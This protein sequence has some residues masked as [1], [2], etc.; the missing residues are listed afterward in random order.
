MRATSG[1]ETVRS[2]AIT[3]VVAAGAVVVAGCSGSESTA[4]TTVAPVTSSSTSA[5]TTTVPPVT[6]PPATL[7]PVTV[8]DS[9]AC[10]AEVLLRV[11]NE[12][13]GATAGFDRARE[14]NCVGDWAM[15]TLN[16]PTTGET[17]GQNLFHLVGGR[18]TLV[19]DVVPVCPSELVRLGTPDDVANQLASASACEGLSES[20]SSSADSS[21]GTPVVFSIN[22]TLE[23][24]VQPSEW[25]V[26]ATGGSY[27][28]NIT[29]DS[30]GGAEAIGHGVALAST[31]AE[32]ETPVTIRA[33]NLGICPGSS[34]L[35]YR[36]FERSS[37]SNPTW[38]DTSGL[39]NACQG[40]LGDL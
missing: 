3:V 5:T 20:G 1:R 11:A 2:A 35:A 40:A 6:L 9:E 4:P 25:D 31:M 23:G 30:W 13:S 18:W 14:V 15:A 21:G 39:T 27:A 26:G 22:G 17:D 38:T 36:A 29:W 34:K 16:S 7:P 28:R 10:T 24:E 32:S 8:P 12:Q 37:S 33:S 19:G